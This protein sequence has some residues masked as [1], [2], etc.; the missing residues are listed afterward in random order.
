MSKIVPFVVLFCAT[1]L[2]CG[3]ILHITAAPKPTS[4]VITVP[5]SPI[6]L[7]EGQTVAFSVT[8]K[9]PDGTPVD[10]IALYPANYDAGTKVY[11][12]PAISLALGEGVRV[13]LIATRVWFATSSTTPSATS[14]DVIVVP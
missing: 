11:T 4:D 5:T 9:R 3:A 6:V 10:V 2:A 13:P 12:V 14:V 7:H 8:A 1:L